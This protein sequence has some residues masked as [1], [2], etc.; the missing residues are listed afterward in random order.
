MPAGHASE[1]TP[2]MLSSLFPGAQGTRAQSVE[3]PN[4]KDSLG[5]FEIICAV[6]HLAEP[7][8]YKAYGL[9]LRS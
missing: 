5:N 6:L 9:V 3:F 2:T 4:V 8:G 1:A 7:A